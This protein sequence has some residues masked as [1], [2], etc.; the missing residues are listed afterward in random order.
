VHRSQAPNLP[1]DHGLFE[2]VEE[3]WPDGAAE[4]E[5]EPEIPRRRSLPLVP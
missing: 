3:P 1:Y 5:P 4:P 2:L